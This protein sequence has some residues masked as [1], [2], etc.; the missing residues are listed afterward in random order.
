MNESRSWSNAAQLL[1]LARVLSGAP[2]LAA[3]LAYVE[4][5]KW[6]QAEKDTYLAGVGDPDQALLNVLNPHWLT[7]LQRLLMLQDY[8]LLAVPL[9]SE[10]TTAG[11]YGGQTL[12]KAP[13]LSLRATS[14]SA[15]VVLTISIDDPED[16][17]GGLARPIAVDWGDGHATHHTLPSGQRTLDVTHAYAVAGRYAIYAVAANESGLHGHAALVV[18]AAATAHAQTAR[19]ILPNISRIQLS[20]LTLTNWLSSKRFGVDARLIDAAGQGF[21]AGRSA[22]GGSG[23]ANVP[24]AFGE[25]FVHNPARFDTATLRLDVRNELAGPHPVFSPY[26][27]IAATM[28]LGVFATS[29]QTLVEQPVTLTPEMLKLYL[30]GASTPMPSNTVTV[31]AKGALHIPL[32]WRAASNAP[33]QKITRINIALTTAMFDGFNLNA[34]PITALAGTQRAWVETRPGALAV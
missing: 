17:A 18:E 19:T 21:R 14:S 2:N 34:A 29:T 33:W 1:G 24:I 28:K 22:P 3:R 23:A 11:Q 32:F 13:T 8:K 10:A 6:T 4:S 12:G 16:V 31:D 20:G 9:A 5:R 25:L 26:M 27:A 7:I 15:G 30:A